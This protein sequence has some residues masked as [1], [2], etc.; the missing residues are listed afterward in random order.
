MDLDERRFREPMFM[1]CM[2]FSNPKN[3]S[4]S[5]KRHQERPNCPHKDISTSS[6]THARTHTRTHAHTHA[7]THARTHTRTHARTHART[8]THTH[9]LSHTH[10][11]FSLVCIQA[12]IFIILDEGSCCELV[13]KLNTN[14]NTHHNHPSSSPWWQHYIS[15]CTLN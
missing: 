8:H 4:S 10:L 11:M 2:K 3:K 7:R 5:F 15:I 9:T 6:C 13:K 14:V 1:K 12:S